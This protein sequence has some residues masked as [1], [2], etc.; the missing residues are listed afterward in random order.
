MKNHNR[1]G[2]QISLVLLPKVNEVQITQKK[3]M[4]SIVLESQKTKGVKIRTGI[5][6]FMLLIEKAVFAK[7]SSDSA[8]GTYSGAQDAEQFADKYRNPLTF[9]SGCWN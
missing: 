4:M 9:W 5:W 1:I 3:I 7:Q 6:Q 2:L 8:C